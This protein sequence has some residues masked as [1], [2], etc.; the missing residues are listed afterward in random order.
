[1]TLRPECRYIKIDVTKLGVP[2]SDEAGNYRLQLAEVEAYN[3]VT[4]RH[5]P[6]RQASFRQKRWV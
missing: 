6:A 4:V 5:N 2:A 3:I 1:V